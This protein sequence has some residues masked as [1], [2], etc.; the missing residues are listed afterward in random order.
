[1]ASKEECDQYAAELTRRFDEL[2]QWALANWPKP[3]F[4]LLSSDFTQSRRE[5]SQIVGPKLGD[6]DE[7]DSAPGPAFGNEDRQFRDINPMPWP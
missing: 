2:V 3:E 5:I 6:A 4:P 7:H 1:M